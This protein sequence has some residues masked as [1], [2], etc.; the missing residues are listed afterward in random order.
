MRK[1]GDILQKRRLEKNLTLEDVEKRTK[2]RKK[3]LQAIEESN[4]GLFTSSTYLRG[5]IKNYSDYLNLPTNEILA[6][7][8]REFDNSEQIKIIPQGLTQVPSSTLTRLTPNKVSLVII[9]TFIILFFGYLIKGYIS[10]AGVPQLVVD[11]PKAGEKITKETVLVKGKTDPKAKLLIN[12]QEILVDANGNFSQ[13]VIIG[14]NTTSINIIAQNSQG[15]KAIV[16]RV[17]E[18]DLNQKE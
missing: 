14:K 7:F 18:V 4:Y 3:F 8:R 11:S 6:I 2:I 16:E 13:E 12:N 9:I 17:I 15:K 1:V 10:I 5:F